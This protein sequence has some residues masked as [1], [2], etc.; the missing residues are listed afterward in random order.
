MT[1]HLAL[2]QLLTG[3]G[4]LLAL[5]MVWRGTVRRR[6]A[7]ADAARASARLV[8]LAGR[9]T[10][11][12]GVLLAAQ[13][14]VIAHPGDTVLLL[15]VLAVPDLLAGHVLVRALTVTTLDP[16]RGKGGRR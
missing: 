4:L 16:T 10:V 7:V 3:A 15:V 8:S 6:R 12:G 14:V 2:W 13:W 1:V 11:T 9:V 5:V